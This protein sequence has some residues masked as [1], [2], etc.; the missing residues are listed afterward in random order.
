[1]IFL[2]VSSMYYSEEH[3]VLCTASQA[4]QTCIPY[5]YSRPVA[6]AIADAIGT[7]DK[8]IPVLV[9]EVDVRLGPMSRK[10]ALLVQHFPV[11]SR[12]RHS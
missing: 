12:A 4:I 7:P 3:P 11:C 2:V 10:Q 1:M 8:A 5:L 9:S 6:I